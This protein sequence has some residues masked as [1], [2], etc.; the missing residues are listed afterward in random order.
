[1]SDIG[2]HLATLASLANHI[3]VH[4]I[5]DCISQRQ[6]FVAHDLNPTTHKLLS[7]PRP[8]VDKKGTIYTLEV[9]MH[10]ILRLTALLFVGL[11]RRY[12]QISPTGIEENSDRLALLLSDETIDWSSYQGVQIWVFII[13]AVCTRQYR[14][15]YMANLRSIA[16]SL[17][18][19]GWVDILSVAKGVVWSNK[20]FA[21]HLDALQA[22]MS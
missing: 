3:D 14:A 15:T 7:L 9:K 4:S 21:G 5:G 22:Q 8:A 18:M 19:S 20:V 17:A 10:E 16:Q 11:L 6:A 12:C 1:M 2:D 13:A